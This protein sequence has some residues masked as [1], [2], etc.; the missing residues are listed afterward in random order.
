M[1][2]DLDGV[3]AGNNLIGADPKFVDSA[4]RDY[5]LKAKSPAIN[6]GSNDPPGALGPLDLDGHPRIAGGTVDIGACE[7]GEPD[8]ALGSDEAIVNAERGTKVRA[9]INITRFGGL[10]GNV[11]VAP[12]DLSAIGVKPEP[13]YPKS[14]TESEVLFKLK[15]KSGATT[16]AHQMIFTGR[17]DSGRE[18]TA[19]FTLVITLEG[20]DSRS[21]SLQ[22]NTACGKAWRVGTGPSLQ[23]CWSSCA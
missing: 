20:N 8:F 14:T 15:I 13:S 12:P 2:T 4:G 19:A 22:M 5:R 1:A 7:L 18:R 21:R 6:A 10:T 16:G 9:G 23:S 11:T 3:N 17:D